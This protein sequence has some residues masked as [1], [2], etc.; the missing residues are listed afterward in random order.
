MVHRSAEQMSSRDFDWEGKTQSRVRHEAG[1][2]VGLLTRRR[3]RGVPEHGTFGSSHPAPAPFP[4]Q[5]TH[6][7]HQGF[8]SYGLG[9]P[10]NQPGC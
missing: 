9:R 7:P 4:P 8:S 5:L 1:D 6:K 2:L 10:L 3:K